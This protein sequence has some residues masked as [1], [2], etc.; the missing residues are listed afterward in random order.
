MRCKRASRVLE[1]VEA[2]SPFDPLGTGKLLD[3]RLVCLSIG[4]PMTITSGCTLCLL[5]ECPRNFPGSSFLG[6]FLGKPGDGVEPVDAAEGSLRELD[7]ALE[8]QTESPFWRLE[9]RGRKSSGVMR[10]RG[11]LVAPLGVVTEERTLAPPGD[12][13][14]FGKDASVIPGDGRCMTLRWTLAPVSML[15]G[16]ASRPVTELLKRLEEL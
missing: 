15:S 1:P 8:L 11:A 5:L 16:G 3:E 13:K 2:S 6:T 14:G 10:G 7:A 12:E 4:P 9:L